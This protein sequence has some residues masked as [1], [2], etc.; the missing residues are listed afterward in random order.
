MSAFGALSRKLSDMTSATDTTPANAMIFDLKDCA[1]ELELPLWG[2]KRLVARNRLAATRLGPDGGWRVLSSSLV[3]YV[4]SGAPDLKPGE[5]AGD[6][7]D[8]SLDRAAEKFRDLVVAAAR[9]QLPVAVKD[10]NRNGGATS[11]ALKLTPE[12]LAAFATPPGP[13]VP[14]RFAT[15]RDVYLTERLRDFARQAIGTMFSGSRF[16]ALYDTPQSYRTILDAARAQVLR[17]SISFSK[18]YIDKTINV[19][20]WFSVSFTLSNSLIA[21]NSILSGAENLAF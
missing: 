12:I 21:D 18:Q 5:V 10:P 4:A 1:V 6:W 19:G 8:N 15:L 3:N 14:S 7:F 20:D 13:T 16:L 17:G 9:A 11:Y 2:V